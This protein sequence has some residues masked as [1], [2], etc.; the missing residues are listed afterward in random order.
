MSMPYRD[1]ER[2]RLAKNEAAR[3]IRMRRRTAGMEPMEPP[4]GPLVSQTVRLRS[5]GDALAVIETQI[6]L[7]SNAAAPTLE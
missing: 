6:N 7:V 4:L 5:V 3:R 1:P 2:Q